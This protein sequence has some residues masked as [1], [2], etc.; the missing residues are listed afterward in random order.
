M[1]NPTA[2][3]LQQTREQLS[4]EISEARGTLKD[5]RH[6]IKAARELI[7]T[8]KDLAATLAE[9]TVRAAL[10]ASV[11]EQLASLGEVTEQ[12]MRKSVEKVIAEFD[13]LRDLLLGNE[14]TAKGPEKR[15]IPELLQDPAILAHAQHAARTNREAGRG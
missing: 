12:Q 2:E 4:R 8:A 7:T 9:D 14:Q 13:K 6:E 11:T 3:D 10:D 15:T 5:L 1:K